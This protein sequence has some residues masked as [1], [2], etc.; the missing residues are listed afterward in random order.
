MYRSSYR[1]AAFGRHEHMFPRMRRLTLALAVGS[2]IPVGPQ[3][4]GIY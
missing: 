4:L 3:E 1:S 2:E